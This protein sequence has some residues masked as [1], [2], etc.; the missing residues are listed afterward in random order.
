MELLPSEGTKPSDGD[1]LAITVSDKAG[2]KYLLASFHGD[3]DGLATK[4]TL[5]AVHALSST[6]PGHALVFGLDANT[7]H[8]YNVVKPG[9]QAPVTD[10]LADVA[11]KGLAAAS[12]PEP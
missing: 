1:L 5:H 9:K 3:T 12:G 7:H 2:K 8:T 6:L 11:S 10:F 4:N